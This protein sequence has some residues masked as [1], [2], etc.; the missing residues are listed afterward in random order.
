MINGYDKVEWGTSIE[1]VLSKYEGLKELENENNKKRGIIAFYKEYGEG[2]MSQRYFYFYNNRLY[3]VRVCFNEIDNAAENLLYAKFEKKYGEPSSKRNLK[4]YVSENNYVEVLQFLF[5]ISDNLNIILSLEDLYEKSTNI[6]EARNNI[7]DYL[8]PMVD[9]QI[10][11]MLSKTF[12]K[13]RYRN[14]NMPNEN[15]DIEKFN[16]DVKE[17]ILIYKKV[18]GDFTPR[19][20]NIMNN[21]DKVKSI[22]NLMKSGEA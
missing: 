7:Y 3:K 13:L 4:Y 5:N 18:V 19:T 8:D 12:Q 20:D 1:D 6:I 22:G 10:L 16:N 21:N 2:V 9:N 15:G 17:I 14:K 11:I